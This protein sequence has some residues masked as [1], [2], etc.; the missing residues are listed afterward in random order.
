M[1]AKSGDLTFVDRLLRVSEENEKFTLEDV[2]AETTTLLMG[3]RNIFS[4]S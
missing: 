1:S 4:I 3:V 2:R